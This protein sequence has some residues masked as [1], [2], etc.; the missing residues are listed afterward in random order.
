MDYSQLK[1]MTEDRTEWRPIN[2][3]LTSGR[4]SKEEEETISCRVQQ[5]TLYTS[6]S[7]SFQ[8]ES[9]NPATQTETIGSTVT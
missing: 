3:G 7:K 5:S 9:S 4:I 2:T 6:H 8:T 1:R